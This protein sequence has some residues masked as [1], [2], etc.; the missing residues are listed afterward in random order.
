M[1][2]SKIWIQ[3]LIKSK[4]LKKFG[5]NWPKDCNLPTHDTHEIQRTGEKENSILHGSNLQKLAC[6]KLSKTNNQVFIFEINK[7]H[8]KIPKTIINHA[9]VYQWH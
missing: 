2:Q 8:E 3:L 7:L 9:Y 1:N 5:Q 4:D 6:E